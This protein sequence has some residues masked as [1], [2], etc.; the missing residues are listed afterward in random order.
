MSSPV[1]SSSAASRSLLSL[2]A[3][4]AGP[5][6]GL[7]NSFLLI[8]SVC[9][10]VFS[11]ELISSI[12]D[13]LS[14]AA[15]SYKFAH[16]V[17]K[18]VLSIPGI[19]QAVSKTVPGDI[20]NTVEAQIG[21]TSYASITKVTLERIYYEEVGLTFLEDANLEVRK[22]LYDAGAT[23]EKMR[24]LLNHDFLVL[25][26][27]CDGDDRAKALNPLYIQAEKVGAPEESVG[28]VVGLAQKFDKNNTPT[29]VRCVECKVP[30]D[31]LKDV[32]DI[33]EKF[34]P[35]DYNLGSSNCMD[36]AVATYKELLGACVQRCGRDDKQ[37]RQLQ[38][39]SDE[40]EGYL[41]K[42]M[43]ND[44]KD[45]MSKVVPLLFQE[46]KKLFAP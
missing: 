37:K 22:A 26:I 8:R 18:S 21:K 28:I 20:Y 43:C 34:E 36:Y 46:F 45:A 29:L 7:L 23:S 44:I 14:S 35:K 13:S 41:G 2:L 1:S 40:I 6:K 30:F 10:E 42:M 17:S 9:P 15:S 31:C 27:H 11:N 19:S 5:E 3:T 33:V 16:A 25:E 12:S 32:V 39:E 24:F 38:K 4:S